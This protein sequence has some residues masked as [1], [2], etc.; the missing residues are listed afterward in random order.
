M[1][2]PGG[3]GFPRIPFRT[4]GKVKPGDVVSRTRISIFATDIGKVMR[5]YRKITVGLI[6]VIFCAVSILGAAGQEQTPKDAPPESKT[7]RLIATSTRS[8]SQED[9]L[10]RIGPGDVLDIRVM[11]GR[12]SPELSRDNIKVENNGSIRIPMIEDEIPAACL[13]VQELSKNIRDLYKKYKKNPHVD[14]FIKEY[15]SQMVAVMG[16]VEKPGQ[17][18]LQRRVR[19]LELLSKAGGPSERA[20]GRIH[21]IHGA[22][23]RCDDSGGPSAKPGVDVANQFATFNLND[24]IKGEDVANPYVLP[25]DVISLPEAEQAYVVGNVLR[26]SAIPLKEPTTISKAMAIAGGMMPDTKVEKVR[27]IRQPPGSLGRT[28][29]VVNLKAIEKR[30]AEDVV[31]QAGD[32]VDVPTSNGKRLLRS[33]VGVIAPTVSQLPVQVIR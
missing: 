3:I 9:G 13:T 15:N 1:R 26:P 22:T 28:E 11:S 32:I 24:T 5:A 8:L 29:I 23:F 27:I 2:V 19:L 18:Q 33:L 14:V 25:G 10:Y 20:G 12:I 7:T 21:I 6:G 4:T 16:A 31:L 30:Q 17:F